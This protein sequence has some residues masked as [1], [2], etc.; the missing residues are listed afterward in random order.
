MVQ[1]LITSSRIAIGGAAAVNVWIQANQGAGYIGSELRVTETNA[2]LSCAIDEVL[3]TKSGNKSN[4]PS[5]FVLYR[6]TNA[7]A[8]SMPT[9]SSRSPAS[10][11][12]LGFTEKQASLASHSQYRY[13][14][15]RTTK[16]KVTYPREFGKVSPRHAETQS[17]DEGLKAE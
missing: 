16:A 1:D 3:E 12:S 15:D 14:L 2:K 9:R 6:A 4:S 5:S 13:R 11:R 17:D 10:S 8:A 7:S